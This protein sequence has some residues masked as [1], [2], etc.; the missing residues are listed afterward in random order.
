MKSNM[1]NFI[2]KFNFFR[3]K[4]AQNEPGADEVG[5]WVGIEF[6]TSIWDS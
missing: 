3:T 2:Q 1:S 6:S 5:R 4:K